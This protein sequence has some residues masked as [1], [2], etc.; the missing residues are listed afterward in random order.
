[1]DK[2]A[3]DFSY[4]LESSHQQDRCISPV[5]SDVPIAQRFRDLSKART[6]KKSGAFEPTIH[7]FDCTDHGLQP[8][9]GLTEKST[10]LDTFEA[11]F[12]EELAD[13]ICAES[14]LY[15]LTKLCDSQ[16]SIGDGDVAEIT[17]NDLFLFHAVQIMMG[18]IHKP[19]ISDYWETDPLFQ[20]PG[21]T[22]VM[23]RDKY[24]HILSNIHFTSDPDSKADKIGKLRGPLEYLIEKFQTVYVPGE[25]IAIDES[26]VAFKGRLS[27][28]QYNR[29]KSSK[30]GVKLYIV[31]ESKTGYV[32][33]IDVYCG[34][35]DE[36][37]TKPKEYNKTE[38]LVLKLVQKLSGK[39]RKLYLDNWYTSV[40]L[41]LKLE[42]QKVNVCGTVR[43]NRKY[44]PKLKIKRLKKGD[45]KSYHTSKLSFLAWKDRRVVTM[46]STMHNPEIIETEKRSY[47]TGELKKKPNV[48]VDYN[49]HMGGVDLGDQLIEPYNTAR[50]S[51][52]WYMKVYWHLFDLVLI[53]SLIIYKKIH[54][55]EMDHVTFR[56]ELVKQI[57]EKYG[58]T[59][60]G[61]PTQPLPS[62]VM[63]RSQ[64][65]LVKIPATEKCSYPT[66]R[67]VECYEKDIRRNVRNVCSKCGVALCDGPCFAN[68]HK[69]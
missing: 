45:M 41:F 12:T 39:G 6:W 7:P 67:C 65:V 8:S 49:I 35:L 5:N 38:K 62:Q 22:K 25:H 50:K 15:Q 31:A 66:K 47:K 2:S 11:F 23:P 13:M 57:L 54:D 28:K 63:R 46:L 16:G 32:Y 59:V 27:F 19:K 37:E 60:H 3:A 48:V 52:K 20:T 51:I 1:M 55:S 69:I 68:F 42:T 58:H 4:A 30:F 36:P 34:K 21:F 33:D 43:M 61:V 18:I 29:N 14:N 9:N 64:H 53:N 10:L 40:D 17:R 56:R 24:S 26:L 44:L